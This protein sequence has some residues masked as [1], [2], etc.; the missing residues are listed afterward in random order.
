MN[1]HKLVGPEVF[2]TVVRI[3]D[4]NKNDNISKYDGW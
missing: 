1:F 2:I 3:A 4:A